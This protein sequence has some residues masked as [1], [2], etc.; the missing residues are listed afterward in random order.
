[1]GPLFI[2]GKVESTIGWWNLHSYIY[3]WIH[4]CRIVHLINC[5]LWASSRRLLIR[6]SLQELFHAYHFTTRL[7]CNGCL[8][9]LTRLIT[10]SC[11]D[12]NT[13]QSP[14]LPKFFASCR[15]RLPWSIVST[16][17]LSCFF[18]SC[19]VIPPCNHDEQW[20]KSV[21]E[22]TQNLDI[23]QFPPVFK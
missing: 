19:I 20:E 13:F 4:S 14:L 17:R 16:P 18:C 8:L 1:M 15:S 21:E 11:Y 9:Y 22:V 12:F 2:S 6:L 10:K 23:I 7:I 5:L 3:I